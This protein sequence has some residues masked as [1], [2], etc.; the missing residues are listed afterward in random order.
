[1]YN[2]I[3][4]TSRPPSMNAIAKRISHPKWT[5]AGPV[6]D[7][8]EK[9]VLHPLWYKTRIEDKAMSSILE[10]IVALPPLQGAEQLSRVNNLLARLV[11][12]RSFAML[13]FPAT[14]GISF[15]ITREFE[16]KPTDLPWT[17]SIIESTSNGMA[18]VS[19]LNP[20]EFEAWL[21]H[22]RLTDKTSLISAIRYTRNIFLLEKEDGPSLEI[23]K[24]KKLS[25]KVRTSLQVLD[26]IAARVEDNPRVW[27]RLAKKVGV[28]SVSDFEQMEEKYEGSYPRIKSGLKRAFLARQV[29][30]PAS[31]KNSTPLGRPKI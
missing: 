2:E 8:I 9:A 25:L 15:I 19:L 30:N 23:E 1:M 12:K 28:E 5:E 4:K 18:V 21:E 17:S 16:K 7:I 6:L 31:K 13:G 14:G 20:V 22:G 10:R 26:K 3:M 27:V 24:K 11:Q 29:D